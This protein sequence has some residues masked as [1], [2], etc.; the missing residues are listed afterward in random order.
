MPTRSSEAFVLDSTAARE[1][2]R[3]VTLF[4]E[5]EGKLRGLAHGAARSVRR[6][7]GR[8]ERLSK[9]RVTWF[10]KE[11]RDLVRI[12]DLE[13]LRESFTLHESLVT[14]AAVSYICEIAGEFTRE[15]EADRRYYRLLG[16]VLDGL[17]AGTSASLLLRYFEVW[18]ARLHGIFPSLESCD[19]CGARFGAG[20]AR[21]TVRGDAALCRR[22]T[23]AAG[24]PTLGLSQGALTIV[25]AFRATPPSGLAGVDYPARALREV[26]DAAVAALTSLTGREIKS[27]DYLR[28]VMAKE[29]G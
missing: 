23:R 8:L 10:E 5:E 19:G 4:T 20:G 28:Q 21:M 1:R 11:G 3:L 22:C 13:L 17:R 29:I 9:V 7:G 15:K 14:S 16:A 12:D 6:F 26:G 18:T 25:E 24:G 2:D 27:A